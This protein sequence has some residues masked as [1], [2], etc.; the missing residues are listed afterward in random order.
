MKFTIE[1]PDLAAVLSATSGAVE[2]R[3]TIPIL[4]NF[5]IEATTSGVQVTATD[6][7]L[8]ITAT[9]QAD[10]QQSGSTTV[11]AAM[12]QGIVAKLQKGKEVSVFTNERGDLVV[13]SG[14]SE[15]K[16][17]TLPVGD[18]PILASEEFQ[19]EFTT[20]AHDIKRLLDLT[21]FAVS[22]E[23]TR[24]YLNGV[25]MH[26]RD[27]IVKAAA[28]DGHRLS[29]VSSGI[30]TEIPDVIIPRKTVAELR[31]HGD[32]NVSVKISSAKVRFDYDDVTIISK[33]IDGVFPDY[34]RVIPRDNHNKVTADASEIKAAVSLVAQVVSEKTRAVVFDI[35]GGVLT[36][37]AGTGIDRGVQEVDVEHEG[38]D[39]R[40]GFN[41]KYIDELMA[42]LKDGAV[43]MYFNKNMDPLLLRDPDDDGVLF[44]A[45]PMRH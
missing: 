11:N 22:T 39:L 41:S 43:D 26:H 36:I 15:V 37:E 21:A 2:R 44:V 24:Y 13:K 25:F 18:F 34:G 40:I 4:G 29:L 8:E 32:G 30:E 16:L 42:T 23:E 27:G 3:N 38:D 33:V 19:S 17:A 31:K 35:K 20:S 10:V 5:K 9:A 45:M 12:L 28:T 14:R 7:D 1:Q 6:L